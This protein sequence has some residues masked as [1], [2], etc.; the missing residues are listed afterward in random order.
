MVRPRRPSARPLP[1][2]NQPMYLSTRVQTTML[3]PIDDLAAEA[4][5][6][7]AAGRD[8][9]SLGQGLTD[10]PPPPA[11]LAAARAALADPVTHRYSPDAGLPLLRE[12][13]AHKWQRDAG[14]TV[15]PAQEIVVTAGGNQ[16]AV[17]ALL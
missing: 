5:H 14:L 10:F 16:A 4:A 9:I 12:A 15:D 2:E 17:L 1:E 7:H 13:I 8:I 11:A 6:L 3:P